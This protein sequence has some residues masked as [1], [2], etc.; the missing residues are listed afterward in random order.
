MQQQDHEPQFLRTCKRQ[1]SDP[2]VLERTLA[3]Y[4]YAKSLNSRPQ[5]SERG[6]KTFSYLVRM[7][8]TRGEG[9]GEV[10]AVRSDGVV[11]VWISEVASKVLPEISHWFNNQIKAWPELPVKGKSN[12]VFHLDK[13]LTAP[14]DFERFKTLFSEL[15]DRLQKAQ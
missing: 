5:W 9:G 8:L 15:H 12:P 6:N 3:Y 7:P 13:H 10:F 1:I 2:D 4:N 11:Q 14:A